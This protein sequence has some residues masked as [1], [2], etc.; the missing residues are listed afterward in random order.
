MVPYCLANLVDDARTT[1]E[2]AGLWTASLKTGLMGLLVL[3]LER[4]VGYGLYAPGP[5]VSF[6]LP[7]RRRDI[8]PR[9]GET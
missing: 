2:T 3:R 4:V 9:R 6:V 1:R 8:D 5:G 7:V